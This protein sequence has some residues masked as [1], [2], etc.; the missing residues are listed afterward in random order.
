MIKVK[1]VQGSVLDQ[2]TQVLVNAANKR[3]RGGGGLDGMFHKACG[4]NLLEELKKNAPYNVQ[5]GECVVTTACDLVNDS[6]KLVLHVAGPVYD[7]KFTD[8]VELLSAYFNIF[9]CSYQMNVTSISAPGIS[10]G[11]FGFPI[12][13]AAKLAVMGL[14]LAAQNFGHQPNVLSEIRFVMFKDEEYDAFYDALTS[15]QDENPY[16]L[17]VELD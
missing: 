9:R 3:M 2:N 12:E 5:T 16:D 14:A 8:D 13:R 4:P 11:I 6:T 15:L 17:E 7:T 10:T 1:L